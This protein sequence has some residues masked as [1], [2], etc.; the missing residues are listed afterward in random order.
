MKPGRSMWML[1]A[2]ARL[3]RVMLLS[4]PP[5]FH[6]MF[7]QEMEQTFTDCSRQAIH[8]RGIQGLLQ[9]WGFTMYDLVTTS[10]TE[11]ILALVAALKSLAGVTT[12][13]V[14]TAEGSLFMFNLTI[15]QQTDIGRQR[16]V[17]QDSLLSYVPEDPQ[18]LARKGA[19][20][21]VSDG[22]GGHASGEVASEMAV[23][24][25]KDAYYQDSDEDIAASLKRA[26]QQANAMIVE[27]ARQNEQWSGMGTTCVAAVLHDD[28]V[29]AAN[30]GDSRVYIMHGDD[31]RQITEDHSVV[32]QE[33]REGK[34][35]PEE[36]RNHPQR[37]M[38]YRCL[39]EKSGVEVDTFT[40][41]VE[42][43]DVLVLC[44]DGL[45]ALVDDEELRSIVRQYSPE[46]SVRR[47]VA[48]A[49]ENGGT[50]NITAIVVRVA[51]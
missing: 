22:L 19:L 27:R 24:V 40:G 10:T 39:G 17:N 1:S 48:R 18:S 21:V 51:L 9:L 8:D 31:M 16:K 7:A 23:Q 44:T 3:Y 42:D 46:E 28:M 45:S 25:T 26:I 43:G 37:N 14:V 30:V 2:S 5:E 20:F 47:L 15:A 11:R 50:D 4:Y 38:I 35:T 33:L 12:T 41:H 34:I 32:A 13:G 49:N 36:A 6:K 29:Y